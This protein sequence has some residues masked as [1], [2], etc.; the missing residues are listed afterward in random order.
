MLPILILILA[1]IGLCAFLMAI[2]HFFGPKEKSSP[3]KAE[4]YECGLA[5]SQKKYSQNSCSIFFNGY[6]V[7]P[8]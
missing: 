5:P 3:A 4:D 8:F 6:F 1:G 7:H 2:P